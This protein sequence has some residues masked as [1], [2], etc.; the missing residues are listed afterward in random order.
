MSKFKY[1]VFTGP[2]SSG[3]STLVKFLSGKYSLPYNEEY[4]R[5][6]LT[7]NGVNY[8]EKD[9]YKIAEGQL[10]SESTSSDLFICD[11]DLLTIF[12]WMEVV[13]S[14]SIIEWAT[15]IKNQK[16]RYYF[17]LKPDIPWEPDPLRE[18]PYDRDKLFEI[19]KEKLEF[20]E[21]D[22]FVIEGEGNVRYINVDKNYELILH[23]S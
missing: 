14:K 10:K 13:F 19:Y 4:A 20:F 6:Y 5:E 12:I 23:N 11:S 9:L 1:L 22:Y 21:L 3:K 16:D 15:I 2:E 7:L 8:T 18:N 17:L